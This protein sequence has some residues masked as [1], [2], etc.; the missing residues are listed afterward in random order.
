[1]RK[2]E[3]KAGGTQAREQSSPSTRAILYLNESRGNVSAPVGDLPIFYAVSTFTAV[4]RAALY[5][6]R[7]AVGAA[8]SSKDDVI[9]A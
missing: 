9:W 2:S 7:V 6:A 1:M 5:A 8:V 4:K 3:E